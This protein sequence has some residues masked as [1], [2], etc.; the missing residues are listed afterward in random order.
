MCIRDRCN[1]NNDELDLIKDEIAKDWIYIENRIL[2][3]LASSMW[4]KNDYYHVLLNEDQQFLK[5]LESV[6][7]A[8]L[9]I[10]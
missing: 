2:A 9:L 5:A 10:D 7:K 8:K 6:E 3:E 1:N 4:S